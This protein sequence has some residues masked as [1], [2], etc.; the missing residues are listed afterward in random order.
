MGPLYRWGELKM[1]GLTPEQEAKARK[2]WKSHPGD[3][4]DYAYTDEFLKSFTQSMDP[5]QFKK[6]TSATQKRAD[7]VMD[8]TLL[9]EPK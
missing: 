5:G 9:F 7:N 1:V 6:V 8:I 4:Y 2:S 3:P